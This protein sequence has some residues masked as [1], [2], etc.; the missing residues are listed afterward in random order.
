MFF[1]LMVVCICLFVSDYLNHKRSFDLYGPSAYLK[2][3]KPWIFG[4]C[5]L[6]Y[7]IFFM[8]YSIAPDAYPTWIY[9][10]TLSVAGLCKFL[11]MFCVFYFFLR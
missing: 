7:F 3:F 6:Y 9:N 5:V 1:V 8:R 4:F 2:G 11:I 10:F